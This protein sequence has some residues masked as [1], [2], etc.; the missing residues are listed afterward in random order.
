L[1]D[2][3]G[4]VTLTTDRQSTATQPERRCCGSFSVHRQRQVPHDRCSHRYRTLLWTPFTH[5][6]IH[7]NSV[8]TELCVHHGT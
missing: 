3:S 6:T 2:D 5:I 4:E 8:P 1:K 7:S